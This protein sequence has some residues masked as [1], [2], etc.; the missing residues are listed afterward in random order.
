MH[1]M[2]V[3]LYYAINHPTYLFLRRSPSANPD[4]PQAA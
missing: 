4:G 2:C 3:R 1:L